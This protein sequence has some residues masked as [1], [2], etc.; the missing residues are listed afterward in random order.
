LTEPGWQ[1]HDDCVF[2]QR[3]LAIQLPGRL[4]T[5]LLVA[6]LPLA[7]CSVPGLWTYESNDQAAGASANGSTTGPFNATQYVDGIWSSKV[8]PTV[9]Q[10]AVEA[11]T[12]LPA[13]KADKAA[14]ATKYGVAATATGG[15]PT[16]LIKGSGKVTKVDAA[17]PNGPVT[18]SV[19]GQDV[20]IV[21]GPVIIGTA[22]R[23]AAGIKFSDFTNQIDYQSVG[24]QLNNRVK[25]D[26]VAPVKATISAGK[27]LTFDGVFT[28]L[29]PTTISIV[30]TKLAVS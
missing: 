23:D 8:L 22:L 7:G 27:T 13:I 25:K 6:V 17:N 16:F 9:D 26:V 12:L 15:S 24:T 20:T 29:S 1:L 2:N 30:P 11:A 3:R 19:A 28:L 5:I 4:A 18:V 10:K 14:A 21:T